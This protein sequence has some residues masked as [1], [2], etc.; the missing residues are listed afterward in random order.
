VNFYHYGIRDFVFLT[1]TGNLAASGFIEAEYLQGNTRYRGVEANFD[2]ELRPWLWLFGGLDA[3]DAE[4]TSSITSPTTGL[5]TPADTP[6]PR[7]PPVRGRVGMDLR[8]KGLSVRPEGVFVRDQNDIFPTETRTPGYALGSLTVSYTVPRAHSVSVFSVQF[9]NLSDR[10]Y[11]NHLS[12][13]KDLSPEI[14]RG[15]RVSAT[16]RFQ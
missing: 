7:I 16:V 6:L 12:F 10:L 13:I 8:W 4:L 2:A 5:V 11:R 3:V 1:P 9:F 14:G 15:V